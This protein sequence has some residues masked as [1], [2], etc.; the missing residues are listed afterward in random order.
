MPEAVVLPCSCNLSM[1][2]PGAQRPP[3]PG[4]VAFFVARERPWAIHGYCVSWAVLSFSWGG[5]MCASVNRLCM[6]P[7]HITWVG[8]MHSRSEGS[9]S[10]PHAHVPIWSSR[11]SHSWL[12]VLCSAVSHARPAICWHPRVY[13]GQWACVTCT[14][15]P[16]FHE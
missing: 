13:S 15:L 3:A 9:S 11:H 1:L 6:T 5:L 8:T 2:P 10:D 7:S 12:S 4:G 16:H 14:P